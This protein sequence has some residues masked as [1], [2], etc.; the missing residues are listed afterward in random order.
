[1]HSPWAY[2]TSPLG[3]LP[4]PQRPP[5]SATTKT[6]FIS[7]K[8]GL[9]MGFSRQPHLFLPPSK[10]GSGGF[11]ACLVSPAPHLVTL[12]FC[13]MFPSS[14]VARPSSALSVP[15]FP[16]NARKLSSVWSQEFHPQLLHSTRPPALQ[17]IYFATSFWDLPPIG[18]WV[19]PWATR[20]AP[21][22][23]SLQGLCSH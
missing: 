18:P 22:I 15:S 23:L 3:S 21:C 11:C 6:I 1:M 2:S 17:R 12:S 10:L 16:P 4:T 14:A 7:F 9:S 5:F 8:N 13:Y 19:L 20:T